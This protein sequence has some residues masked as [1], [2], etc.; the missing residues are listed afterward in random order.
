M[1]GY[2][3]IVDFDNKIFFEHIKD[4]IRWHKNC[5]NLFTS[6]TNLNAVM[7]IHCRIQQI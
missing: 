2:E 6:K 7:I 3:D 1:D 4:N 5:Y